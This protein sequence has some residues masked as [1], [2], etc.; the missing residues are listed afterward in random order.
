[1]GGHADD[2]ARWRCGR[3]A[4]EA[5]VAG[6]A[7][8]EDAIDAE[9]AALRHANRQITTVLED[10]A[11][12]CVAAAGQM[13]GAHGRQ[14][15]PDPVREA[16][17]AFSAGR[18]VLEVLHRVGMGDRLVG[19]EAYQRVAASEHDQQPRQQHQD[20]KQRAR[21]AGARRVGGGLGRVHDDLGSAVRGGVGALITRSGCGR[22][23]AWRRGGRARRRRARRAL[24]AAFAEARA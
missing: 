13:L 10:E 19:Q 22:G 20:A 8:E 6:G 21:E 17:L 23:R 18:S 11:E 14:G 3:V 2:Q 15:L 5:G 12:R 24:A 1:M 16:R 7:V 9:V 4:N